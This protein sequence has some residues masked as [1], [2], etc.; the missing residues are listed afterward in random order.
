MLGTY[1]TFR[2]VSVTRKDSKRSTKPPKCLGFFNA[3]IESKKGQL[4]RLGNNGLAFTKERLSKG[5]ALVVNDA[6]T[7]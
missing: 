1:D 6:L 4:K 5:F 3:T 7:V 2:S